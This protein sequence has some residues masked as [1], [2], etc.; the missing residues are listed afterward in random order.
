MALNFLWNLK[1]SRAALAEIALPLGADVPFFIFGQNAF[2]QGVGENLC[3]I[4]VPNRFYLI[5]I[6]RVS[7]P[8]PLIF[9]DPLLK[10]DTPKINVDSWQ[11]QKTNDL[12]NVAICLFPE[13]KKVLDDFQKAAPHARMTGSGACFFAE[14]ENESAAKSAQSALKNY[15]TQ[16]VRG[17]AAHPL[18]SL[19][20]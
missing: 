3:A 11:N 7:C 13:L 5:A 20:F 8:T 19:V 9:K 1:L 6:P 16:I 4:D 14:F 17:I 18:Q 15:Q 10:R 12:Q 2:G